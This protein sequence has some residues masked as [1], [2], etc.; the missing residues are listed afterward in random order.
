MTDEL[1]DVFGGKTPYPWQLVAAEAI[2][3]WSSSVRWSL[4]QVL[5]SLL[6]YSLS[7]S[8]FAHNSR[9]IPSTCASTRI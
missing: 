8:L 1:Q 4:G 6:S 5:R 3:L 2:V 9:Y 7:L